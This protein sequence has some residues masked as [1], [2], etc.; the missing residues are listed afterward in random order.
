VAQTP[1]LISVQC[2]SCG[3]SL[4]PSQPCGSY[5]CVYCGSRF[6]VAQV[7]AATNVHG[8]SVDVGAL[9]REFGRPQR[10]GVG[11]VIA[12]VILVTVLM[13]AGI[14]IAVIMLMR[15][16]TNKTFEVITTLPT[17]EVPTPSR[18]PAI[19]RIEPTPTPAEPA[20]PAERI[21]VSS[22]FG[23]GPAFVTGDGEA[24]LVARM[25][26]RNPGDD[27][28]VDAYR[29]A[30]G[31]RVWRFESGATYSD[32]LARVRYAVEGSVVLVSDHRAQ[33]HVLDGSSGA[34]LA[35]VTL[36]DHFDDFCRTRDDLFVR[37]KDRQLW[38]FDGDSLVVQTEAVRDCGRAP[39]I[40]PDYLFER[41]A[42][43]R[44]P[45]QKRLDGSD[46][47]WTRA[48][49]H[50]SATLLFGQ[51]YPGTP[52]ARVGRL[53]GQTLA[54]VTD[55]PAGSLLEVGDDMARAISDGRQIYVAHSDTQR[56]WQLT[57]IDGDD[58]SRRWSTAIP[59][60]G[61][62]VDLEAMAVLD[63]TV[64]VCGSRR[65][66]AYAAATGELRW[67]LADDG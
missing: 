14:S 40:V 44:R 48:F 61:S 4:P 23:R 66:D 41:D 58:G 35:T 12:V 19:P 11:I 26:R 31:Q 29:V 13:I 30:D 43:G 10:S 5:Q 21:W 42:S 6:E 20:E 64:V 52:V 62:V 56:A 63:E 51:R 1:D 46:T 57:A 39:A 3:A 25:R 24:L 17:V 34:T 27:L 28:L 15:D 50:G 47:D 18:A 33:V 55:V 8:A 16:V 32:G 9:A 67:S 59:L 7:R 2:P 38:R 45:A 53:E 22:P 60:R 54:W 49:E 37:A 65:L 36:G